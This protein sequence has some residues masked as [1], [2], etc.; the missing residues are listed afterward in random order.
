MGC[1]LSVLTETLT[2]GGYPDDMQE[3]GKS[4]GGLNQRRLGGRRVC[5][6]NAYPVP[7][8]V[9]HLLDIEILERKRRLKC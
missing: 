7:H 4:H 2:G 5:I 8:L 1:G 9:P 3:D 6:V